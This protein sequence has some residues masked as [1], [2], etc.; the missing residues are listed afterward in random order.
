MEVKRDDKK[1]KEFRRI[2]REDKLERGFK[3]NSNGMN[4]ER[5]REDNEWKIYKKQLSGDDLEDYMVSYVKDWFEGTDYKIIHDLVLGNYEYQLDILLVTN[6]GCFIIEVKNWSGTFTINNG[7]WVKEDSNGKR[8]EKNGYENPT[9]QVKKHKKA[10]KRLLDGYCDIPIY[11][12]IYIQCDELYSDTIQI[13]N[14]NKEIL[15]EI[16][17]II[18]NNS[19]AIKPYIVGDLVTYIVE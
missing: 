5:Y 9:Q 16:Q 1:M 8:F 2:L 11:T 6:Y 7:D 17:K 12:F 10:L 15:K 13:N 18:I 4:F 14:N 19:K 3:R